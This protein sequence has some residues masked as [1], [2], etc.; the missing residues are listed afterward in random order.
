MT[1]ENAIY[2]M[3]KYTDDYCGE[4]LSKAVSDA[5]KMAISALER[6]R[7]I[8]VT[9][10]LP[11]NAYHKGALCD[12]CFITTKYGVTEGW[13]NP[14]VGKWYALFWFK[15]GYYDEQDIHFTDGDKPKVVLLT[16]G[17]V[18]AWRPFPEPYSESEGEHER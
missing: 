8:P 16:D 12:R 14:D 6:D 11:E 9:E 10:R 2:V 13:Y 15:Y 3:Q 17:I 1:N 5:H 7:W 18:I 4:V